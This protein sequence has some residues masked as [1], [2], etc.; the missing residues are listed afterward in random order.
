M[1]EHKVRVLVGTRKGTYVIE[2]DAARKN[3][4]VNPV[5]HEGRDIYHAVADPRHPGTLYAAVN[6]GFW[7]PMIHRSRNWGKSWTE[8]STPLSPM[9]KDRPNPMETMDNPPPRPVQAIWHLEPGHASEPTTIFAGVDPHLLFRSDDEGGTWEPVKGLNEHPTRPQWAPG[10]GGPAMHTIIVDPTDRRRMYV[11]I[12]AAGT[13]K[14]EDSGAHWRP[15]N[16]GVETPFLPEKF[17]EV[18]QC[19]HHVAQDAAD[20][21]LFYRQ[22][23]GGIYVSHD[24]MDSWEHVGKSMKGG[25]FG[26]CVSSPTAAPGRAYF[27]PLK[28]EP[29]VTKAGGLQ[30]FQWSEKPKGFKVLMTPKLFPGD[31]GVHR[32]GITT[33]HEEKP[34]IYVGTTTGQLVLSPDAGK[35]WREIPFVFPSIHS[36]SA[37]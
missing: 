23:H 18:G 20:P 33:D 22:D 37:A 8:I 16:K 32:E 31:F 12:S 17:P 1:P 30:V 26:F 4:K 36:V 3:W 2:S 21:K 7:G 29:R 14:S 25:D 6:S 19:V 35:S 13:F 28:D 10:A 15:A 34:G 24:A 11:G 9:M 5:A 27:V